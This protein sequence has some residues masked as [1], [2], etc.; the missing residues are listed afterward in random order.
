MSFGSDTG[1]DSFG[2]DWLVAVEH[3]VMAGF[4]PEQS[5]RRTI[6]RIDAPRFERTGT[7][8]EDDST[9]GSRRI[10]TGWISMILNHF[11]RDIRDW[12][13]G[14]TVPWAGS[15]AAGA[16]CRACPN[17]EPSPVGA[18]YGGRKVIDMGGTGGGGLASA[19]N[20][21]Y[22]VSRPPREVI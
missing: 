4:A 1:E 20:V 2:P 5:G 12:A 18:G 13:G 10:R 17:G 8:F 15:T 16:S 19:G 9:R 6:G 11:D 14:E 21:H 3:D 22:H 7:D